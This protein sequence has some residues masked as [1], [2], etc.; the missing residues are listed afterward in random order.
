MDPSVC[1]L[2]PSCLFIG[3]FR[4]VIAIA[5]DPSFPVHW[6]LRLFT[7]VA[8]DPSCPLIGS[9]RFGM[10]VALDPPFSIMNC[11]G[12]LSLFIGSCLPVHWI[13]PVCY[14]NCIGF[15]F[16]CSL[17][18]SAVYHSCI[19]SFLPVH[20]ILP[21]CHSSCIGSFFLY[22]ELHWILLACSLDPPGLS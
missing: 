19:G 11:I 20:W 1:S 18:P 10:V 3:S 17:D 14:C 2:D 16:L 8:L 9:S 22:H 6:I 5:L 12:S 7:I 21:V 4:F 13:L 15:F